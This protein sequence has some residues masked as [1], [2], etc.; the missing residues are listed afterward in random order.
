[1]HGGFHVSGIVAM[2]RHATPE[3]QQALAMGVSLFIGEAEGGRLEEVL[4]DAQAGTMRPIYDHLMQ[5]P[6]LEDEPGPT[7]PIELLRQTRGVAPL[8]AGRGC[9]FICSFCTI[10]NVHGRGGRQRRVE[11]V[12]ATLRA[13]LDQGVRF[14]QIT[15]DNF[16]RLANWREMLIAIG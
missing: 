1:M 10:I 9:P 15:D 5:P 8:D 2:F 3:L 12:L 14:F 11:D 4:R 16:A 6:D 7:L 13:Y